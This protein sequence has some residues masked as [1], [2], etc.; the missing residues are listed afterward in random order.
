MRKWKAWS[1]EDLRVVHSAMRFILKT[2]GGRG[3]SLNNRALRKMARD[4]DRSVDAVA[5]RVRIELVKEGLLPTPKRR[6]KPQPQMVMQYTPPAPK[7]TTVVAVPL[8]KLYG[9]VDFET[10]MS[11]INE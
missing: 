6:I 8:R 10:F 7:Q 4:L 5:A 11:L 2:S 3:V 1:D 9:K